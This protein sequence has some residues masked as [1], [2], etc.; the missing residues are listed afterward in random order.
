MKL[1]IFPGFH[2]N[3]EKIL[4]FKLAKPIPQRTPKQQRLG[5]LQKRAPPTLLK[6]VDAKWI[7]L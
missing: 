1:Y 7:R 4:E 5:V 6:F 3:N 2:V